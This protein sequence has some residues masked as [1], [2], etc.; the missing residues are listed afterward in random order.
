MTK[1]KKTVTMVV[2]ERELATILAALRFHQDEN[3]QGGSDIPDQLI[4][5]IATN[6]GS[7]KPLD[8]NE[9]GKLCERINTCEEPHTTS[10]PLGLTIVSPHK[11]KGEEPL[12]RVVYVID[13]NAYDAHAAAVEAYQIMSDTSSQSPVLQVIDHKGKTITV[14]L[15]EKQ[16][17][18]QKEHRHG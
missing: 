3:L 15:S 14:D 13:L 16:N 9:V 4:K 7:L 1:P 12:F 5:G 10:L 18:I 11:E 8:F 17:H 2:D 6:C